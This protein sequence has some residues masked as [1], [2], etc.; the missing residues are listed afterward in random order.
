[1]L[2]TKIVQLIEEGRFNDPFSILGLHT[3][4]DDGKTKKVIRTYQPNARKVEVTF[5]NEKKK[6]ELKTVEGSSLFEV[7]LESVPESDTYTFTITWDDG[8]ISKTNDPYQFGKLITEYDLHLWGEGNHRRAFE[9]LGTH[10]KTVEGVEGVHFVIC[11]PSASRV[12]VV[13]SFN[14]W[15]GRRH[16]M[17]KYHDQGLWEIFISGLKE[18]EIYKYEIVSP[19]SA[20]PFLK[21]DPYG[22]YYEKRPKTASIIKNI[23]GFKWSDKKW[24]HG[25]KEKQALDA[26]ISVYE[27]HLGSWKRHKVD[28]N[29]EEDGFY[30]YIDLAKELIPYVKKLGFTHIELLPIAE[31]PYDPSWGYQITG[32]YAPTSRYGTP[33]DLMYFINEC[34]KNDLGVIVDWVPAHFTKDDHGLREFD[35]T[36][37]YEHSDPRQG[38]HKD[39]GTKIFNFGRTEV[40]NFLISNAVFWFDKYHIDGIRVDAV[41]SMLYLDYSRKEGDW[42]PNKYGGRENLEAI[43]FLKQFNMVVHEEFEGIVTMAEESTAWP[44]VSRPVYMGGLGFDFKWNMGW[45]NDT[46]KYIEVD[47][48]FRKYHQDK[49]TFSMIYAFSENFVLPF[50]HDEVV[51]GKGSMMSKMPGDDWQKKANLKVLYTYMF[52]HPGKKL[53]FMGSEFGQ[54]QEWNAM[55]E[56]AWDQHDAGF[57]SDIKKLV[58]KLNTIYKDEKALHQVDYNWEGFEW[59]DFSDRDNC[60][61]SFLRHSKEKKEHTVTICNFT[62]TLNEA[63]KIG[64]PEEGQYTVVLNTDNEEFGGSGVSQKSAKTVNGEW[65]GSA[66]FIELDIPPLAGIILKKEK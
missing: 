61:I 56:L 49:L 45:M 32:Y 38:E 11:A 21:S 13:G 53:L 25:R 15:D 58:T 43:E 23:D 39:W 26:P 65:Q 48:I 5:E 42:I 10:L 37:L 34:H 24:M 52:T 54:W 41:A 50:S 63:Y 4:Q 44:M 14:N 28:E 3:I 6:H 40:K 55:S 18:N 46:L 16:V 9:F 20:T 57:H 59:I 51:H 22:Y 36:H 27:L 64:V 19:F 33:E 31:H 47:P 17:R 29:S 66:Q 60:I 35:G 2:N 8:S 1:M 7:V 30:S 62:P 12:S